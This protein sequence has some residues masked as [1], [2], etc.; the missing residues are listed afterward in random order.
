[1]LHIFKNITPYTFFF[2]VTHKVPLTL[3]LGS[4][5]WVCPSLRNMNV[6]DEELLVEDIFSLPGPSSSWIETMIYSIFASKNDAEMYFPKG[7]GKP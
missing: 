3:D 5:E 4:Q 6:A 1:M 2:V 7:H